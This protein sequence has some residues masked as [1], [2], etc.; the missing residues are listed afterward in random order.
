M[1]NPHSPPAEISASWWKVTVRRAVSSH[2]LISQ[3]FFEETM[4][5]QLYL[6]IMRTDF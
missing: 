6:E 2:E 4:D 1:D 3:I 5:A